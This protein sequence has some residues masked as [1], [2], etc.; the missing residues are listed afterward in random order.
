M[1]KNIRTVLVILVGLCVLYLTYELWGIRSLHDY[2]VQG[3]VE[4]L[5]RISNKQ[6]SLKSTSP[7]SVLVWWPEQPLLVPANFLNKRPSYVARKKVA[8][9]FS[10]EPLY[11]Q[12]SLSLIA[13]LPS[14]GPRTEE[15]RYD[16]DRNGKFKNLLRVFAE[17]LFRVPDKRR[18]EAWPDQ[19]ILEVLASTRRDSEYQEARNTKK[20]PETVSD[21]FGL[22]GEVF[23]NVKEAMLLTKRDED[24]YLVTFI[25]CDLPG[26]YPFPHCAQSFYFKQID[27]KVNL[28]YQLQHLK[29]WDRMQQG[30]EAL[31]TMFVASKEE[32]IA[33]GW[34]AEEAATYLYPPE[35]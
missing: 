12:F 29:D 3:G 30:I 18:L 5:Q 16:L 32:A 28:H 35:K 23:H 33:Y 1:F 34:N 21:K 19:N 2:I 25:R 4:N 14:I 20:E 17:S 26:S 15:N 6:A 13:E 22:K 11:G 27:A 10:G 7:D 8:V 9:S 31:L 24:N